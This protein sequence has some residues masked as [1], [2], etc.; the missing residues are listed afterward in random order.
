MKICCLK[1]EG[2]L[3]TH[4]PLW[5][6]QHIDILLDPLLAVHSCCCFGVIC[7]FCFPSLGQTLD[8]IQGLCERNEYRFLRLDGQT[9]T[10]H[11]QSLVE[12]FNMKG[13][14]DCELTYK[15]SHIS[16]V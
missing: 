3:N 16:I 8:V 4:V 15:Y 7:Y 10:S 9:A 2:N 1:F 14:Q 11:R 13:S 12:R 5:A 6:Q